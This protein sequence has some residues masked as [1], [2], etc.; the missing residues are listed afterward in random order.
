[1]SLNNKDF[2]LCIG[3]YDWGAAI[4]LKMCLKNS[5]NFKKVIAFHPS[6]NE[7]TNNELAS[8]KIPTLIQWVKEDQFHPWKEWQKLA[9]KIKGATVDVFSIAKFK[10]EFSANTYEKI[11]NKVTSSFVKFITG[12]DYLNP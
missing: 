6:Y 2:N 1:M 11:S 7:E 10:S 3:G 12:V 8:I 5:N 4:A 9:K